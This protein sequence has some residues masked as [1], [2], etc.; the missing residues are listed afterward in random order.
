MNFAE[1][2]QFHNIGHV[3]LTYSLFS[4]PAFSQLQQYFSIFMTFYTVLIFIL[5]ASLHCS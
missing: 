5:C 2:S 1:F 4:V 3:Y